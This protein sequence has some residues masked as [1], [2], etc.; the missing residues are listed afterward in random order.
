MTPSWYDILDLE[1]SATATEIR[2]AWRTSIADLDP[3]DRRF[4]L[5]NQAAEVLLDENRRREYDA[6]LSDA[7][8]EEPIADIP[9]QGTG[10]SWD[11][12]RDALTDV[13]LEES[14]GRLVGADAAEDQ[15]DPETQGFASP[16][17]TLEK[18]PG[19]VTSADPDA[20]P[21]I[22]ADPAAVE[23]A[24]VPGGRPSGLV[25]ALLS[26]L[27]LALIAL[28]TA[29]ILVQSNTSS[30]D[31][32]AE[33][34]LSAAQQAIV[35]VLSYDYRKMDQ[36]RAAAENFLTP[37]YAKEYAKLFAQLEINLPETET[38]VTTQVVASGIVSAQNDEVVAFLFLNRPTEKM[39][40]EPR[41][42]R[43]QVTVKMKLVKDEWLI[44]E[45]RTEAPPE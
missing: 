4:R 1:P 26:V 7:P 40:T 37:Q 33:R 25:L 27:A 12:P 42:Y 19:M 18:D 29:V 5:R 16:G 23:P 22:E 13:D 39:N 34:G 35:P 36:S 6:T 43:D 21:R 41:V 28:T 8:A 3:G 11:E 24:P 20:D 2:D 31:E 45:L 9:A 44:D 30:T 17:V 38:V 15:D 14:P 10:E 32:A